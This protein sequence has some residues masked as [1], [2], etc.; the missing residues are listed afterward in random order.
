MTKPLLIL[1]AALSLA[2]CTR[3]QPICTSPTSSRRPPEWYTEAV[4]HA[5]A[6]EE[7][8]SVSC[9]ELDH[10]IPL[11]LGGAAWSWSNLRLQPW[12]AARRKDRAENRLHR[13][14]CS[15][16][17]PLAQARQIMLHWKD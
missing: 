3:Q 12:P 4:K 13:L 17:M 6:L 10:I 5:L 15:G 16:R 1:T 9:C 11:E 7:G 14:V 2:A 8:R